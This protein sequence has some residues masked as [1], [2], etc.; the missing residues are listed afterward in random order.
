VTQPLLGQHDLPPEKNVYHEKGVKLDEE[1]ECDDE[2]VPLK[3]IG[4]RH[5]HNITRVWSLKSE[6]GDLSYF[7][8]VLMIYKIKMLGNLNLLEMTCNIVF[9]LVIQLNCEGL[10]EKE[11]DYISENLKL[12]L[13]NRDLEDLNKDS[14]IVKRSRKDPSQVTCIFRSKEE[15]FFFYPDLSMLPFDEPEVQLKFEMQTLNFNKKSFRFNIVHKETLIGANGLIWFV[16]NVDR[17]PEYDI[18]KTH[19]AISTP[20]EI[21]KKTKQ[22]YLFVHYPTS[23]LSLKLYRHPDYLVFSVI[24]P[25]LLCNVFTLSSFG[26]ESDDIGTKLGILVTILLALFAFTFTIRDKIPPVPY[27]TGLEKQILLSI[28]IL[29]LAGLELTLPFFISHPG[30]K[31]FLTNVIVGVDIAFIAVYSFYFIINYFIYKSRILSY[32]RE[33]K[34]FEEQDEGHSEDNAEFGPMMKC[35]GPVRR[36][37]KTGHKDEDEVVDYRNPRTLG[38]RIKGFILTPIVK[39]ENK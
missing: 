6:K 25:L 4:N 14:L 39:F 21:K 3:V 15:P 9:T 12:R 11:I 30:L 35:D 8:P 24:V 13:D 20:V 38:Q 23:V 33:N 17:I 5:T 29:F 7:I 36:N 31:H 37:R 19:S 27:L 2:K 26:V 1:T 16:D 34:D 10:E 28:T 18:A 32:D 22:E